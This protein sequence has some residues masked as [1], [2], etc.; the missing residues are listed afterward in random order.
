MFFIKIK[1]I[2]MKNHKIRYAVIRYKKLK[3]GRKL[4]IFDAL[5]VNLLGLM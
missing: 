5:F 2:Y 4:N 1:R 3:K